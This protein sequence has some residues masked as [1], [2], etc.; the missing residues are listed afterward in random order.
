MK[1]QWLVVVVVVFPQ[2]E[3]KIVTARKRFIQLEMPSRKKQNIPPR[4]ISQMKG[5]WAYLSGI[6]LAVSKQKLSPTLASYN[7]RFLFFFKFL[8]E[9][10]TPHWRS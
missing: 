5:K 2:I 9:A 1:L 3:S 7:I 6:L 4:K 8:F 10:P